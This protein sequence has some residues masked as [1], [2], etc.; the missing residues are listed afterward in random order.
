MRALLRHARPDV[1]IHLAARAG[2]IGANR[3]RPAEFFYENLM[4]GV[5][6]VH[7]SWRSGVVTSICFFET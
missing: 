3:E 7:E 4:I 6:L 2:G 5:Q 1:V